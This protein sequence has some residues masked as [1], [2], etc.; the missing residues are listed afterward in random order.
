ML[1]PSEL[2]GRYWRE[3]E[4]YRDLEWYALAVIGV[5]RRRIIEHEC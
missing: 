5:L 2:P 3:A 4:L 1:Y